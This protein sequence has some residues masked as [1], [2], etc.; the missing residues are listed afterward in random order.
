MDKAT[1]VVDIVAIPLDHPLQ[2]RAVLL[3]NRH[4]VRVTLWAAR[5]FPATRVVY[6][7]ANLWLDEASNL[8]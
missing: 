3:Y 6:I 5:T 2:S 4:S 1:G 7:N 8:N